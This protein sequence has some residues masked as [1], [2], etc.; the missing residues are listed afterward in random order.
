[1]A[2]ACCS[3]YLKL[4]GVESGDD[5]EEHQ[6]SA[7]FATSLSKL[8]KSTHFCCAFASCCCCCTHCPPALPVEQQTQGRVVSEGA[9]VKKQKK[10]KRVELDISVQ[11]NGRCLKRK[12]CRR[13]L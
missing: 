12:C 11:H 3:P 1:M 8:K 9:E 4:D 7:P 10:K 5:G 6:C 13:C 2:P